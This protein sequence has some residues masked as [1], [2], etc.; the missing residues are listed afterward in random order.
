MI[1][2]FNLDI[3]LLCFESNFL[4]RKIQGLKSLLE[5][6]KNIKYNN[7]KFL[8]TQIINT[9]IEKNH[10][11][12]KIYGVNGHIELIKRSSDFI[13]YMINENLITSDQLDIIWASTKTGVTEAK[14]SIYKVLSE[15]GLNLKIDQLDFII[16]KVSEIPPNELIADE[17]EL[18]YELSRFSL[19]ASLKRA[20]ISIGILSVR[21]K[22]SHLRF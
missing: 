10:L 20:E 17:I 15:I 22:V 14:L 13:K 8:S 19:R 16:S 9:I 3:S 11:F 18:V 12:E 5:I 4:E 2:T 6:M 7:V 21:V 1:E